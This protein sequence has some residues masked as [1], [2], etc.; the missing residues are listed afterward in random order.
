MSRR[1]YNERK[2]GDMKLGPMLIVSALFH[3][4]VVAALFFAPTPG[5]AED[6]N[7]PKALTFQLEVADTLGTG[8]GGTPKK[9]PEHDGKITL[10]PKVPDSQPAQQPTVKQPDPTLK[11]PER[12]PRTESRRPQDPVSDMLRDAIAQLN[13][14]REGEYTR[15]DGDP[16]AQHS[17][18]SGTPGGDTCAIYRGR[19]SRYIRRSGS[20]PEAAGKS[21]K[22]VV[23]ISPSGAVASKRITR[24]SGVPVADKVA[25]G[26]VPSSFAAPPPECGSTTLHVTVKFEGT[27]APK[28]PPRADRPTQSPAPQPPK[29]DVPSEVDRALQEIE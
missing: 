13:E 6:A 12:K 22:I 16:N 17:G 21:V 4:A 25:M 8:V 28:M 24:S 20:V 3:A 5:S 18:P 1:E 9:G 19:A 11:K 14:G 15:P 10:P 2:R 23:T 7:R 29:H 26:L 27:Q